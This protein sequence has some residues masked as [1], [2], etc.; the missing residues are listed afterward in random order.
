MRW[1]LLSI[2]ALG[3]AGSASAQEFDLLLKGGHV[4]DARSQLNAVR[5]VAIKDG[6]IKAIASDISAA[7][8]LKIV[9]V[10]GLYVTP[11]LIDIHG[12][13]YRP[14]Y[15]QGFRADNAAV[16][17]DGFSFRAGVTT[18]VDPG[19]S[20]WRNFEDMKDKVIDRSRTRVLALINIVGLGM[21]GGEYEQDLGDMDVKKTAEMALKHKGVIVGIKSAHYA[22]PEW[23]PF[24]RAV[25]VGKVADIPVMVDFGSSRPER[26]LYDLLNKIFRP[27]DIFTHVYGG[28]R[29]E[30]DSKT[31]G[32]SQALIDGRKRGVLFDVG[33]GAGSFRWRVAVPLIKAGFLPDTI[34]T[35]LHTHSMNSTVKD[36][37]NLMSKF[38]AMGMPL[39]RVVAA[40]TW[41][42]ARAIKQEHLGHLAVDAVADVAVLRLEKGDFGFTDQHGA[43][44]KGNQMLRC[45]LTLRDG[46]VVYDLNDRT[47][48][49]WDKLPADYRGQGDPRWDGYAEPRT[50]ARPPRPPRSRTEDRD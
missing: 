16:Y 35:D 2:V 38:L 1:M 43:R 49:D 6:K 34:S 23:D 14:T 27:G 11:G 31:L 50:P 45:E 10:S 21:A 40:N 36:M 12:H 39:D 8:A 22:G 41:N 7:R 4:I 29:G 24:I 32:P 3:L 30:Q 28:N 20:G 19:G 18:F 48:E 5:D 42:A 33:H 47:G 37:L 44:L 13:V 17:P 25:E 15:G 46:K 26:P 9:D